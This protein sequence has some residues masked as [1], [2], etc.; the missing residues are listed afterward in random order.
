M[1]F[2]AYLHSVKDR[3]ACLRVYPPRQKGEKGMMIQEKAKK[4]LVVLPKDGYLY[5]L[6][7]A[8]AGCKLEAGHNS[9]KMIERAYAKYFRKG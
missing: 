5:S 3:Q 7:Q 8:V 2:T 1:Y 4:L 6:A 9:A